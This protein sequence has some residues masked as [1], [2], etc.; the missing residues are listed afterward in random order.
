MIAGVSTDDVPGFVQGADAR[1][2]EIL[3]PPILEC[4]H[5][6]EQPCD[7]KLSQHRQRI[8]Q[9]ARERV[10][11]REH[12][13]ARWHVALAG[14]RGIDIDKTDGLETCLE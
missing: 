8:A 10:V 1:S 7:L 3:V 2:V 5:D 13:T 11:E 14:H 12:D 9:L 6:K 4:G